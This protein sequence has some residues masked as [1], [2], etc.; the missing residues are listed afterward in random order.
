[1]FSVL[2]RLETLVIFPLTK[3]LH[4]SISGEGYFIRWLDI[5]ETKWDIRIESS[6]L[7]S[8]AKDFT[9]EVGLYQ[10]EPFHIG[11][12]HHRWIWFYE[13]AVPV[14][15]RSLKINSRVS[16]HRQS[17]MLLPQHYGKQSMKAYITEQMNKR[18]AEYTEINNLS[19]FL[20]T[21]NCAGQ[22]PIEPLQ[23]WLLGMV[24]NE[25]SVKQPPDIFI[26]GLQEMCPLTATN[27]LGDQE[28]GRLWSFHILRCIRSSF[29]EEDYVLVRHK[30]VDS[31]EL[32]GILL[33][34]FVKKTLRPNIA[35]IGSKTIK[36]GF[37]G[38]AGN[39]GAVVI[40]L[41][42]ND[43]KI[44]I[45]N[46]HL[47]AHKSQVRERNQNVKLIISKCKFI[48]PTTDTILSIYEHE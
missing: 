4:I 9:E 41:R 42:L 44:C 24:N 43:A 22:P 1:M 3:E 17:I 25:S 48:D 16:K 20:G 7:L 39:K 29:T 12:L 14:Q 32:V 36:L 10:R 15:V 46:S 23:P 37:K 2:G 11:S 13:D 19:I 31:S 35:V 38:Y 40:S 21:W 6:S 18:E 26:I 8:T 33:L 45:I 34:V 30:Q 28:R 5:D 47:A 27:I